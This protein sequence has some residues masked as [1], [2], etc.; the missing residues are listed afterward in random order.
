V[1]KAFYI[2][3]ILLSIKA[4]SQTEA[5]KFATDRY[6][7]NVDSSNK[8]FSSFSFSIDSIKVSGKAYSNK[9]ET[10]NFFLRSQTKLF[11]NFYFRNDSLLLVA[12]N[13]RQKS[14]DLYMMEKYYFA[15]NRIIDSSFAW[16]ILP[17]TAIPFNKSQYELYGYNENL[18]GKFMREYIFILL[19][20]L[21]AASSKNP[22]TSAPPQ[23]P[24]VQV[25]DT[26]IAP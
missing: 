24:R 6:A 5:K 2:V 26:I 7:Y 11:V 14:L 12:I 10:T 25:S 21:K 16:T 23:L 15:N 4:S 19:D 1:Q 20:K 3:F 13:E 17:C 18:H 22:I 8:K 9:I